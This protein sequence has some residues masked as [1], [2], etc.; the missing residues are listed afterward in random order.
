MMPK[1]YFQ[2][3]FRRLYR[4]NIKA[5]QK[6][7]IV[8]SLWVNIIYKNDNYQFIITKVVSHIELINFC[9][10]LQH[11]KKAMYKHIFNQNDLDIK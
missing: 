8:T 6:W 4:Q 5:S 9:E 3:V 1:E 2:T 10:Y 11:K 7:I